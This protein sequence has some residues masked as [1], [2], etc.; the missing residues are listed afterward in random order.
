MDESNTTEGVQ[1][2][3][4]LSILI[5]TWNNLQMLQCCINSII[6]HSQLSIQI[7]VFVN[8]GRDHTAE[9]LKENQIEHRSSYTNVG[10]CVAMNKLRPLVQAPYI[11]YLNDDMY[12]L[13]KWDVSIFDQIKLLKASTFMISSTM[14]EPKDSGNDTNIVASYG[15]D[16][17]NFEEDKLLSEFNSFKKSNWSGSSWP[18]L[19]LPTSL[20]DEI[21]GFSEEFS[22]GMYSDPDMAMKT[23][24]AG[25]RIYLGV[26]ESRVYHFGSKSTKRVKKNK[27]RLTFILKWGMSSRFFYKHFLKMGK[28]YFGHLPEVKIGVNVRIINRMKVWKARWDLKH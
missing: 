5:P 17:D 8:E 20:W 13:P 27:G 26:G 6:K 4:Q 11:C 28:S 22:P 7:L 15:E 25:N 14:I 18:P 1:G 23:W 10:I 16:L 24:E 2:E 19:F 21:D 12:V 9:W 3:Y